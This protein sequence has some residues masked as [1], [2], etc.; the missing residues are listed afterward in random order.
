M[1]YLNF[2]LLDEGC[3]DVL[4]SMTS[5]SAYSDDSV[6]FVQ[7]YGMKVTCVHLYGQMVK[8]SARH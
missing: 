1:S 7:V 3:I 2:L 5:I 6:D 4:E 8:V